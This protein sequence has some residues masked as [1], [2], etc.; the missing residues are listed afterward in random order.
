MPK[1]RIGS[2][3]AS[4]TMDDT[5]DQIFRRAIDNAQP[6]LLPILEAEI[7][8][9][10]ASAFSQWPVKTGISKAALDSSVRFIG[11]DKIEAVLF[12]TADHSLYIRGNNLGK[13]SAYQ[14]LIRKPGIKLAPVLGEL[15]ADKVSRVLTGKG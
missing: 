6:G 8:K 7:G 4:V 9:L 2:G 11:S 10:Y 14:E 1:L 3:I 5:M 12:N 13:K 15:L